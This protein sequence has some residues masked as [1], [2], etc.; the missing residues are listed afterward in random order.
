MN[1][2]GVLGMLGIGAAGA[3]LV[4]KE[5]YQ[6][7]PAMYSIPSTG[8]TVGSQFGEEIGRAHV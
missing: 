6:S 4:A 5:V 1:R 2:R 3:P 7:M 8:V